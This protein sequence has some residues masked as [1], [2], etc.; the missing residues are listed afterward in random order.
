MVH[1]L[2]QDQP[3]EQVAR[4][5]SAGREQGDMIVVHM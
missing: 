3:G 2:G 1:R 4:I 5:G